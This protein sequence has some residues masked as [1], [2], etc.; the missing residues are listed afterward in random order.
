MLPVAGREWSVSVWWGMGVE[1][2]DIEERSFIGSP[3]NP[4]AAMSSRAPSWWLAV[5]PV[6]ISLGTG[7]RPGSMHTSWHTSVSRVAVR[8]RISLCLIKGNPPL[9][10]DRACST[11][12][13]LPQAHFG[14]ISDG[15][16]PYL[17]AR[18]SWKAPLWRVNPCSIRGRAVS[19]VDDPF[20]FARS[21]D[22]RNGSGKS[23]RISSATVEALVWFSWRTWTLASICL[24][25][26]S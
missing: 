23:S 18:A 21:T 24:A 22:L 10:Q 11:E 26:I 12:N 20:S 5:A 1:H 17:R 16:Q 9:A 19:Q 14:G 15:V 13:L 8:L 25:M 7:C 6:R 2:S 4:F 3:Q